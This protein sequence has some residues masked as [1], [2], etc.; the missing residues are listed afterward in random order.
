MVETLR[1]F[2]W[3]HIPVFPESE[4]LMLK[5]KPLLALLKVSEDGDWGSREAGRQPRKS[6][7][8][9]TIKDKAGNLHRAP[10]SP[11]A[12]QAQLVKNPPTM[13]ETWVQSP[14]WEG[15]IPGGGNDYPLQYSGLEK[16]MGCIIHGLQRVGHD[17]ATFTFT[18]D[19]LYACGRDSV[20]QN[21]KQQLAG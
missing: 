3:G 12:S 19:D 1:F 7:E 9:G 5:Q 20:E 16:S 14:G 4:W 8:T 6:Q 2:S 15:L 21:E 11:W 10:C 17:W 13:R 18:L